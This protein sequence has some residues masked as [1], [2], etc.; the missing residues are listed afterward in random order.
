M[1]GHSGH[2][3][4]DNSQKIFYYNCIGY[5]ILLWLIKFFCTYILWKLILLD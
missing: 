1:Q 3:L 5:N 2:V 4:S